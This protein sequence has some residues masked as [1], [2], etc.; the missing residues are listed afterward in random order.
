MPLNHI[1]DGIILATAH[2]EFKEMEAEG[3]RKLGKDN[4]VLYDLRNVYDLQ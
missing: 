2:D 1:Y 4:H 3:I